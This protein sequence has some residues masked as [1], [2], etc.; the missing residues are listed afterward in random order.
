MYIFNVFLLFK[1]IV[2]LFIFGLKLYIDVNT[3]K[4]AVFIERRD[5]VFSYR[6]VYRV[7]RLLSIVYW[8]FMC[9]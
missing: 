8:I 5:V 3:N 4:K 6:C 9:F 2:Y 1:V 7:C